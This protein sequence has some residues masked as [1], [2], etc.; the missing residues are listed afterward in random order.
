MIGTTLSRDAAIQLFN[1]KSIILNR[2]DYIP[3]Y[4][5][6]EL[7]GLKI[8]NYFLNRGISNSFHYGKDYIEIEINEG[9]RIALFSKEGFLEC[10]AFHNFSIIG[11]ERGESSIAAKADQI[12]AERR[13]EIERLD[14]ETIAEIER[15]EAET[16][17]EIERLDAETIAE[18]EKLG[19]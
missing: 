4:R 9:Q 16:I 11:K 18:I 5:V 13:A 10:V 14:A 2:I 12:E 1:E 19:E 7:L 3:D 15:L 17:A 8:T 6:Y